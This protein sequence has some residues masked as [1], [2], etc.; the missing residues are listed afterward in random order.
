MQG[1]FTDRIWLDVAGFADRHPSWIRS[2][3]VGKSWLADQLEPGDYYNG[4]HYHD[5]PG[6]VYALFPIGQ[7][8]DYNRI[9]GNHDITADKNR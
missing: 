8:T 7:Y 3:L 9:A 2:G 1:E 6:M 4:Q 5:I